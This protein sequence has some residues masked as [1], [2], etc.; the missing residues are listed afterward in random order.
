MRSHN[1]RLP[2]L[3]IVIMRQKQVISPDRYLLDRTNYRLN[4]SLWQLFAVLVAIEVPAICGYDI[5]SARELFLT[6]T[7]EYTILFIFAKSLLLLPF[8][9]LTAY[10]ALKAVGYIEITPTEIIGFN[11]WGSRA[12]LNWQDIKAVKSYRFLGLRHLAI[13][14]STNTR[15]KNIHC[16]LFLFDRARMFDRA[17]AYAGAEHPVTIALDKELTRPHQNPAQRLCQLIGVMLLSFSIW[18]IGGNLVAARQEEPLNLAIA[19]YVRQHPVTPPNQAAI[20]LQAAIAKLGISVVRFGDGTQVKVRPTQ[21]A[22]SEWETSEPVFTTYISNA[23]DKNLVEPLPPKLADYLNIHRTEIAAIETQLIDRDL[24]NW[25]SDSRWIER[26]DDTAGDS[27]MSISS[28]YLSLLQL[29]KI[30][31]ADILSEQKFANLNVSKKLIALENLAKS[32]HS[33]TLIIDKLGSLISDRQLGQTIR[34]LD[35]L[36]DNTVPSLDYP[37]RAKMMLVAI[38]H[39]SLIGATS[40]QDP[41]I[42]EIAIGDRFPL[43]LLVKYHQFISPSNRLIAVHSYQKFQQQMTYWQS[44]NICRLDAKDGIQAAIGENESSLI[45][46]QY[47]RVAIGD[48]DRE[49]TTGVRQVKSRLQ[50]GA[51]IEKVASEFKF[52][53]RTCPNEKWTARVKDGGVTISF[54]QQLNWEA[55]GMK[56]Q[57]NLDRF[58]YRVNPQKNFSKP[59]SAR[60]ST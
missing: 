48:L 23:L 9:L 27:L 31:I 45:A 33:K 25:G 6:L 12:R 11:F 44:Q 46:K 8:L 13:I 54:S 41:K 50:A 59:E 38:E 39:E 28:N 56:P 16:G 29:Q 42:F 57:H 58:T 34:T 2:E 26:H 14:N 53:S 47:P 4:G 10:I 36:P 18:S 55:L 37:E 49:L 22:S 5:F 35:R 51:E 43:S 52:A 30:L 7:F 21:A 20:D 40:I 19:N 3:A 15:R 1:Q 17:I 24:P 60:S 32:F